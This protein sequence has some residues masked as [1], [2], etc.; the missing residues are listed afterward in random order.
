MDLEEEENTFGK[1]HRQYRARHT[2]D[3]TYALISK[4]QAHDSRHNSRDEATRG[5]KYRGKCNRTEYGI[6]NVVEKGTNKFVGY[7][8][9]YE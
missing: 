2:S 8:A 6:R 3:K 9:S 4:Y 5:K 1:K 7:P